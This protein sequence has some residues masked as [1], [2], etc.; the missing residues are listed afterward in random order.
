MADIV[1]GFFG[2]AKSSASSAIVSDA[3]AK[4]GPSLPIPLLELTLVS[5]ILPISLQQRRLRI[6]VMQY[7]RNFRQQPPQASLRHSLL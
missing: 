7:R 1:Q 3:G 5:Q 2:G 4:T 6:P